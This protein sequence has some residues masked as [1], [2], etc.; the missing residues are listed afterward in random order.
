MPAGSVIEFGLPN[1]DALVI[2]TRLILGPDDVAVILVDVE[3]E[4]LASSCRAIPQRGSSAR[5]V[6]APSQRLGTSLRSLPKPTESTANRRKTRRADEDA[7]G[8][9]R[10]LSPRRRP[11]RASLHN[12]LATQ[13]VVGS[14]PILRFTKAC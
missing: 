4:R 11:L 12:P 9:E 8:P 7:E 3:E 10:R 6:T 13:K 5:R 2:G 14:S 1:R